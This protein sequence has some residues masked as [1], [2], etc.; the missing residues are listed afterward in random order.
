MVSNTFFEKMVLENL[1]GN[2][3]PCL[4]FYAYGIK[5]DSP[6]CHEGQN[7]QEKVDK[8]VEEKAGNID[9]RTEEI[10]KEEVQSSRKKRHIPSE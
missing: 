1:W 7:I 9:L 2:T 3:L 6:I 4:L 5:C 8:D 10:E